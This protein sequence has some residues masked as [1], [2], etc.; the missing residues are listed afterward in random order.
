MVT[1]LAPGRQMSMSRH[2]LCQTVMIMFQ[3]PDQKEVKPQRCRM[4]SNQLPVQLLSP[5]QSHFPPNTLLNRIK[6]R[7]KLRRIFL[8]KVIIF[9]S[10]TF[11]FI[12]FVFP[13]CHTQAKAKPNPKSQNPKSLIPNPKSQSWLGGLYYHKKPPPPPPPPRPI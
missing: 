8:E 12:G 5:S 3:V 4:E 13:F 7:R 1:C 9:T 10:S 2:S 11:H 6:Q